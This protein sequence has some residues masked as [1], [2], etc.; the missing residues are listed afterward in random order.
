MASYAYAPIEI[1]QGCDFEDIITIYSKDC[2]TN[3]LTPVDLS[4]VVSIS[5]EIINSAGTTLATLDCS[6][7]D[8]S[9]GQ[10]RIYLDDATTATLSG[11]SNKKLT[12]KIGSYWVKF[13]WASGLNEL[14][15]KGPVSLTEL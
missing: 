10:Y 12:E 9:A 2:D 5:G 13:N 15:R 1:I 11:S 6:V 7:Y 14:K 8:V 3:E 4:S